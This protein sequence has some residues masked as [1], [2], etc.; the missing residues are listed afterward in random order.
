M[1]DTENVQPEDVPI[2][3]APPTEV[4]N[5]PASSAQEGTIVSDDT[6]PIE[7]VVEGDA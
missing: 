4:D 7:P 2:A 5:S 1:S 6:A 3:D